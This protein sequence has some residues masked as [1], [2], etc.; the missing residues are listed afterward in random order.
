[1]LAPFEPRFLICRRSEM[2]GDQCF[3]V[4]QRLRFL[5]QSRIVILAIPQT[6]ETIDLIGEQELNALG[7][8][9]ILINIARGPVVNQKA[10]YNALREGG[11]AAA[12]LDVW[13]DYQPEPDEQGRKYPYDQ[14]FHELPNVLLSP[15]RAGHPI[16]YPPRWRQVFDNINRFAQGKILTNIV[17][18]DKGY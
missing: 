3:T 16:D 18:L 4:A 6:E 1:M 11:I 5:E 10:L 13:Y 14:P 17:D 9:G 8:T 12:G 2:Q 15:H 7:P